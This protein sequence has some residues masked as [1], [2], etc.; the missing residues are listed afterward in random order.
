MKG[1]KRGDGSGWGPIKKGK[2]KHASA[3]GGSAMAAR[4]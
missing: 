2:K 4:A 1:G 3:L